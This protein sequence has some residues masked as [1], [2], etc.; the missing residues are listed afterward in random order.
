MR[1]FEAELMADPERQVERKIKEAILALR[2]DDR[3]PGEEGKRQILEMYLNQVYYG[4]N[5]YGMWAAA[6]AYFGKDISSD[7]PEDQLTVS[8]AAML[9]SL[10][11]APSRLDPT[12]E[13]VAVE[14]EGGTIYVVPETA[15]AIRTRNIVLEQMLESEFITQEQYDEATAEQIV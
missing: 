8:E 4:N 3:Y 15:G 1:L 12:T 5:A 13:A 6:N 2:L 10:V 9:A 11:R 14:A 7:A